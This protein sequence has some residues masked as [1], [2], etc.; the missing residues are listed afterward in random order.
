MLIACTPLMKEGDLSVQQYFEFLCVTL[1]VNEKTLYSV[2]FLRGDN[3]SV[4]KCLADLCSVPIIGCNSKKRNL[5]IERWIKEQAGLLA[6]L[7]TDRDFMS[8]LQNLKN[9][10]SLSRLTHLGAVL[11]NDT[12][13]TGTFDMV[14]VFF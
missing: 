9:A 1:S 12:R 10:A 7:K 2:L 13:W 3:F 5:A 8:R 11:P 6:A 4:N 14:E